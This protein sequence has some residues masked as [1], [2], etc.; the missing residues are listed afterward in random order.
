MLIRQVLHHSWLEVGE[1]QRPCPSERHERGKARFPTFCF[2]FL[3]CSPHAEQKVDR[4]EFDI[5]MSKLHWPT[6]VGM[7]FSNHACD[8]KESMCVG[9][10]KY[11]LKEDM[12]R[13]HYAR[14]AQRR[15]FFSCHKSAHTC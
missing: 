3:V 2:T 15:F 11:L 6:Y 1:H 9:V 5:D 10:K 7:C 13:V 12:A 8:M 4:K 14:L